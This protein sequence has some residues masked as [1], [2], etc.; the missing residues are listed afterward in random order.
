[1]LLDNEFPPDVRV[2]NEAV[3][4]SK[5]GH[6]VFVIVPTFKRDRVLRENDQG[7]EIIRFRTLR[8]SFYQLQATAERLPFYHMF[9]EN[10][11]CLKL[12]LG[13][14]DV[15]HVHDLPLAKTGMRL[16]RRF[17]IPLVLDLHENYPALLR[18]GGNDRGLLKSV[19]FNIRR[20]KEYEAY[21]VRK[22][23][24]V[25]TVVDEAARRIQ[26]LK[27]DADRISVVSNTPEMDMFLPAKSVP[28]NKEPLLT[29]IGGFGPHRGLETVIHAI[30]ILCS[31]KYYIRLRMIGKG[32]NAAS[33]DRLIRDLGLQERIKM[34]D[35]VPF[36][37]V[38]D[39][40]GE[41][42]ACLVPHEATE[43][44]HSTIPHKLFQYMAM[45]KPVIVSNCRPLE[46]IVTETGCGVVFEA[47]NP[48]SFAECVRSLF[49]G[50]RTG[51]MG[52]RGRKAV[53]EKYNWNL[54][55]LKL[56]ELYRNLNTT[57]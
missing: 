35:W 17:R 44:T 24:A 57:A 49:Q 37:E 9:W 4:L 31:D 22:A 29:Y 38:P 27:V 39:Y 47:G 6:R 56:I 3:A 25:I 54:E 45:E 15:V 18:D 14:I 11:I 5:T 8:K 43:H 42:D 20:W 21:A 41:S 2:Q 7:V 1:M 16:C 32:R 48:A 19:F 26:E 40:I 53:L 13:E 34:I 51:E 30:S 36:Q 46:R 23:T 50:N 28:V 12:D 55:Q 33:Y 52:R 10:Q